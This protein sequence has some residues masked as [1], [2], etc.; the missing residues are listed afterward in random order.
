MA[1]R[2]VYL[3]NAV[4]LAAS[5]IVLRLL[6]TPAAF[7]HGDPPDATHPARACANA[8]GHPGCVAC[9]MELDAQRAVPA[10]GNGVVGG[11]PQASFASRRKVFRV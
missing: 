10:F 8:Q 3:K 4:W 9:A 5:G 2:S 11:P 6:H 7:C 1:Q